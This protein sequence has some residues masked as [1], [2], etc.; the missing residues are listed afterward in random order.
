LRSRGIRLG[1][2]AAEIAHLLA[3]GELGIL[4]EVLFRQIG[5]I[6]KKS[7]KVSFNCLQAIFFLMNGDCP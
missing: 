1:G 6:R 5:T 2:A 7:S 3:G 4:Q